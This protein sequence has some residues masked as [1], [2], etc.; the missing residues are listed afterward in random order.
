[1]VYLSARG[2]RKWEIHPSPRDVTKRIVG[3]SSLNASELK[4]VL[5]FCVGC[6]T[7]EHPKIQERR[8]GEALSPILVHMERGGSEE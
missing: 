2:C 1:M 7:E 8:D 5:E 3:E 4:R 6:D